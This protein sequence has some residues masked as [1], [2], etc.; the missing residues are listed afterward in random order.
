MFVLE[1]I[2]SAIWQ[3]FFLFLETKQTNK[4]KPTCFVFQPNAHVLS[5]TRFK[6]SNM[7]YYQIY[8]F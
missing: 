3:P 1:S 2:G 5:A 7:T 6:S 8:L 4:Q